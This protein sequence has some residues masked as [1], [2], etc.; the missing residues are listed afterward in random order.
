MEKN[1][2]WSLYFRVLL[3]ENYIG[4]F[5]QKSDVES[6]WNRIKNPAQILEPDTDVLIP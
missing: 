2:F 5:L 4:I 1:S 6:N 3:L